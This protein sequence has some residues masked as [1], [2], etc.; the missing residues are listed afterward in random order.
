MERKMR[1]R[2]SLSGFLRNRSSNPTLRCM[3]E[4]T[5]GFYRS[6]RV[7]RFGRSHVSSFPRVFASRKGTLATAASSLR[8]TPLRTARIR[9]D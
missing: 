3:L 7:E 2:R 9:V 5:V 4:E 6:R 1:S 8:E